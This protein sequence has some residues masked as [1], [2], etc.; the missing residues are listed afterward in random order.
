MDIYNEPPAQPPVQPPAWPTYGAP[1]APVADVETAPEEPKRSKGKWIALGVALVLA[2]GVVGAVIATRSNTSTEAPAVVLSRA[3]QRTTSTGTAHVDVSVVLEENGQK[4]T[5][6]V[7][8]GD[9]NFGAHASDVTMSAQGRTYLEDRVLNGAEYL[10][11]D[12]AVLPGGK[13]WVKITPADTGLDKNAQAVVSQSDPTQGLQFL[14]AVK[15]NPQ[16]VGHENLGGI[17]VTHYSFTI[18]LQAM[19]DVLAKAGKKLNAPGVASGVD[20]LKQAGVDLAHIPG[21][22]WIDSQGRVRKFSYSLGINAG[23]ETGSATGTL[24][25]SDFNAPVSVLAPPASDVLPF[26]QVPDYF[27]RLAQGLRGSSP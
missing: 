8:S 9:E 22:A 14:S 7:L 12:F 11:S 25:F 18:D 5:P 13:S 19:A 17:K 24:V 23:G 27:S 21:E 3:S 1:G 6:F 10:S 2:V 16:V 4:I 20:Q 26:N 15:G